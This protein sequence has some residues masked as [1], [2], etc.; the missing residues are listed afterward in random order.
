MSD[1]KRDIGFAVS[2]LGFG[3]TLLLALFYVARPGPG[4]DPTL[5]GTEQFAEEI[6]HGFQSILIISCGVLVMLVLGAIG[7]FLG[8]R[9]GKAMFAMGA[10][11]ALWFVTVVAY[12]VLSH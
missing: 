7:R 1:T 5:D 11:T 12:R 3:I 6:G 2:V 9:A 10:V 4:A 8:S